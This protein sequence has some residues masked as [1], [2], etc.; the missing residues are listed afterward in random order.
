VLE[1]NANEK[2]KCNSAENVPEG[3][4]K[5]YSIKCVTETEH[6]MILTDVF[7][8]E[9]SHMRAQDYCPRTID[10]NIIITRST[11][12]MKSRDLRSKVKCSLMPTVGKNSE[13][14]TVQVGRLWCT[15]SITFTEVGDQ[16]FIT[17]VIIPDE[18][19]TSLNLSLH[20]ACNNQ[21]H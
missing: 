19:P 10:I 21:T 14:V 8:L 18:P 1:N 11:I 20:D 13:V 12:W 4:K 2:G 9:G 3:A 7:S 17:L 5:L 15:Y 6:D 16:S